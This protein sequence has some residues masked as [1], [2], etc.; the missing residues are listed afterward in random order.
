MNRRILLTVLLIL[1]GV[2]V[3]LPGYAVVTF[4]RPAAVA[5]VSTPAPVAARAPVGGDILP[6]GEVPRR[7]RVGFLASLKAM[8]V[9]VYGNGDAE[10]AVAGEVCARLAAGAD[11]TALTGALSRSTYAGRSASY[12]DAWELVQS[13][14]ANYC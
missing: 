2:L 13:A 4:T 5:A 9:P 1:T 12:E 8:G 6:A 3:G 7:D 11:P 10:V 14:Q